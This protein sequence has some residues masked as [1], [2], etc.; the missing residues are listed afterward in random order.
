MKQQKVVR[1]YP[2]GYSNPTSAL[3]EDLKNGWTVVL[4]NSFDCGNG[5]KG[6]EYILEKNTTM[7]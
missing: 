6:I 5:Q 3:H 2:N 1:T 4:S 7:V